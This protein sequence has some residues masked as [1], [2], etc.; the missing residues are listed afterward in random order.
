MK[1]LKKEPD[2]LGEAWRRLAR[3]RAANA[4]KFETFE[5]RIEEAMKRIEDAQAFGS[6]IREVLREAREAS[7]MARPFRPS[8]PSKPPRSRKPR[9]DEG[10]EPM[11]AIPGPKP[12]PLSGGAAA[13][14]EKERRVKKFSPQPSRIG[15]R[16]AKVPSEADRV[17]FL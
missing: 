5:A 11:P 1:K 7:K 14:V 6:E 17:R 2:W 16:P 13:P 12:R 8:R 9:P 4:A 3:H 15:G 10:G